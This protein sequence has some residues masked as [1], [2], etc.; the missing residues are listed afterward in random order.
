MQ[1]GFFALKQHV[2]IRDFVKGKLI[3]LTENEKNRD[4][5]YVFIL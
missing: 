1:L 4:V 2:V 5:R 3:K